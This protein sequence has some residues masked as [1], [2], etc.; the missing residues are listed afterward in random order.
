MVT[1]EAASHVETM[2]NTKERND[3]SEMPEYFIGRQT[4]VFQANLFGG[5]TETGSCFSTH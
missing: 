5:I 1:S 2:P 3:L 4:E